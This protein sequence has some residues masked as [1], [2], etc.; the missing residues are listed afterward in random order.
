MGELFDKHWVQTS[1][2][3]MIVAMLINGHTPQWKFWPSRIG[4]ALGLI[5]KVLSLWTADKPKAWKEGD[6][7]RRGK[8]DVP[9][10]TA[11][12][13]FAVFIMSCA[14]QP[15]PAETM[16]ITHT[17]CI[18]KMN[19]VC[20]ERARKCIANGVKEPEGCPAMLECQMIRDDLATL[21]KRELA[22]V[23]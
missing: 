20:L 21:L 10:V 8:I 12:S 17:T 22:E 3:V 6:E 14:H 23:P 1:E 2:L 18:D 15:G 11:L 7:D 19:V 5:I 4:K 16:A 9:S 13:L